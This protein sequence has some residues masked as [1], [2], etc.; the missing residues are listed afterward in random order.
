MQFQVPQFTETETK[1][2]GP[3]TFKQVLWLGGGGLLVYVFSFFLA[4]V[5]FIIFTIVI[6]A[7]ALSFAF[8]K[9]QDVSLIRY[10]GYALAY[11]LKIEKY[12]YVPT[13][14]NDEYLPEEKHG[15]RY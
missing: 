10:V 5:A 12:T 3:L 15:V 1:L 7:T 13:Q 9:I 6:L 11:L 2:V 14:K 8:I 4:G